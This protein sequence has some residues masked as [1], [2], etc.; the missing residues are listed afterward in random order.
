MTYIFGYLSLIIFLLF[1]AV[2]S[3]FLIL[4]S[5]ITSDFAKE[6]SSNTGMAYAIDQIYRD[7]SALMCSEKCPCAISDKSVFAPGAGVNADAADR[8]YNIQPN[9]FKTEL[10]C[11]TETLS[12]SHE[13]KYAQFLRTME[14]E[15]GCAGICQLPE[16]FLFSD[17]NNGT[18]A[19][20]C[21]DAAITSVHNNIWT[22][23]GFAYGAALLGF[24]GTIFAG[25]IQYHQTNNSKY[26]WQKYQEGLGVN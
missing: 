19:L 14:T 6:C 23:A 16:F 8:K 1:G 26:S 17:I 22:Y 3:S 10:E 2:G 20:M 7:G 4:S 21:K 15:W 24:I 9:G 11:P 18:P 25:L 13:A 12:T 5:K